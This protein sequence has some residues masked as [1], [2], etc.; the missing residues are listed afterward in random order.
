MEV[1]TYGNCFTWKGPLILGYDRI[2]KKLDRGLCNI[3]WRQRFQDAGIK[4][5]LR[6]ECSDHN[7]LLLF[8]QEERGS[9]MERPFRF[10][11]AWMLRDN[12]VP[13]LKENWLV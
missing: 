1:Q 13:I 7:P 6:L 8:L 2:F 4:V 3:E 9:G 10:E 12:F 11:A 5:L